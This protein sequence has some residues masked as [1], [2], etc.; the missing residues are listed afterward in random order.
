MQTCR[1]VKTA[2]SRL[3]S[4]TLDDHAGSSGCGLVTILV[5]NKNTSAFHTTTRSFNIQLTQ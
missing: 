2:N 1:T 4:Y 5:I 3:L